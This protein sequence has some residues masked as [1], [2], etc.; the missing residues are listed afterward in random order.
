MKRPA[1]FKRPAAVKRPATAATVEPKEKKQKKTETTE[2]TQSTEKKDISEEAEEERFTQDEEIE[3]E[4]GSKQDREKGNNER[5]ETKPPEKPVQEKPR[6][7][8]GNLQ[9]DANTTAEKPKPDQVE[10]D[11]DLNSNFSDLQHL[12]TGQLLQHEKYMQAVRGLKEGH[13]QEHD[14]LAMFSHK[15]RQGLFKVMES[16]R[17]PA[18]ASEWNKIEGAGAKKK[19]QNFLLA[20]LKGG[21]Q[22]SQIT[23]EDTAEQGWEE[24]K[25]LAWVSWKKITDE[26]GEEE[27]KQRVKAGL[28]QMRKDPDAWKKGLK[29]WQFLKVDEKVSM[30]RKGKQT[31]KNQGTGNTTE[32]QRKALSKAIK[33]VQPGQEE[34]TF[35]DQMW[36]GTKP[37]NASIENCMP[38]A[39]EGSATGEEE[40]DDLETFLAK[41]G[42]PASSKPKEVAQEKNKEEQKKKE[43]E[44]KEKEKKEKERQKSA[45]KQEKAVQKQAKEEEKL[46]KW[47]EN[48]DNMSNC[49]QNCP[50]NAVKKHIMKMTTLMT[51]EI[52]STKVVLK[53]Q[54]DTS[55][56]K[57]S[58]DCLQQ[59][60]SQ[61][62]DAMV[63]EPEVSIA[64][65]LLK[66]AAQKLKA[67]KKLILP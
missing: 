19:K 41:V 57:E 45:E 8:K 21:L 10:K 56:L 12:T 50:Q 24:N 3:P 30:G 7:E 23:T 6:S 46:K 4:A 2:Q 53:K 27:G 58:L 36:L 42:A 15:Q 48:V 65:D 38:S 44:K 49:P 9:T 34:D 39:S 33:S 14:F 1:A 28:I 66:N 63:E 26:Y 35:F 13:I 32:E 11:A 51:Q 61:L 55:G 43:K 37:R 29:I 25:D 17:T 5:F 47:H 62:E 54:P 20:F 40:E 59:V 22:E 64:Q 31:V 18:M 60:H 67:N 16:K 52:R